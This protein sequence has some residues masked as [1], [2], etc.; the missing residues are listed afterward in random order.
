MCLRLRLRDCQ[1]S[2][3]F[4]DSLPVSVPTCTRYS[5]G[6]LLVNSH[7][8]AISIR[9]GV[10]K[11][12][13]C[14]NSPSPYSR[15]QVC[16][17]DGLQ[18]CNASLSLKTSRTSSTAMIVRFARTSEILVS[19]ILRS[20]STSRTSGTSTTSRISGILGFQ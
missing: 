5:D 16:R 13:G 15:S 1:L 11:P 14:S 18:Y 17:T 8:A 3:S 4:S 9:S 10:V 20:S 12:R 2:V 7:V 6:V 19:M